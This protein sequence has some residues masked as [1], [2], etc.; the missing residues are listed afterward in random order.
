MWTATKDI[1]KSFKGYLQFVR[2]A[3]AG[4]LFRRK[5]NVLREETAFGKGGAFPR[6]TAL[7]KGKIS[8]GE[9]AF[10]KGGIF[11]FETEKIAVKKKI[12]I[13]KRIAVKRRPDGWLEMERTSQQLHL[14]REN[15]ENMN[16]KIEDFKQ[17]ANK[18]KNIGQRLNFR[19]EEIGAAAQ[20]NAI[21]RKAGG[22]S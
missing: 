22:E 17:I 15:M 2:Q 5:E 10:G 14:L 6:E 7:R 3:A 19:A 13:K 11:P 8:P 16:R 1:K 20:S 4:G 12:A 18:W 21:D 9:A